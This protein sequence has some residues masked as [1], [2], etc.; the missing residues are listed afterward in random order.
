VVAQQRA[1][2]PPHTGILLSGSIPPLTDWYFQRPETGI[3][4]ASGLFPGQT[5]V[6]THGEQTATAPAAQGGTGKTQLAVDFAR[7][8]RSSGAV[9]VLVWVTATSRE[10]VLVRFAQAAGAVGAGDPDAGTEAAA[11]RFVAWLSH[12]ERPW[13]LVLD[14]L[15]D[16]A[17]LEDL[18]PAGPA[19]Q[20]VITTRVPAAALGPG[21]GRGL[22]VVPVGG[23][24]R[25]EA[26]DYLSWRLT[27]YPDQRIEALDLGE[28]LDGLPLGLAQA[29][30]VMNVKGLSCREYRVQLGERSKH[31]ATV[32][33]EGVSAPILA[34]WS[35]AAECADELAPAGLAWPALALAAMFDPDGIPGVVLTS[36]AACGYIA[37]RLSVGAAPDQAMARA[38]ITNLARAGLVSIDPASQVRTVRLHP[39]VQAAV[40][41]WIPK[42]DF[43]RLQLAAA[44]ALVQTW[45]EPDDGPLGGGVH[46]GAPGEQASGDATMLDQA[47]GDCAAHLRAAEGVGEGHER[48]ER[49]GRVER[50]QPAAAPGVMWTP[51]AHPVLFRAGLSLE[52]SGLSD[53]TIA[54]WQAMVTTCTRLLGPAHASSVASKERLALAYESAGRFGDAI[55]AFQAALADRERSQGREHPD[56]IGARG[57]LA[58]AYASAG[59]PAEAVALYEQMVADSH[60]Q[61]GLGHPVTI[62][63][64]S[65]LA[66][67]YREAGRGKDSVSAYAKLVADSERLLGAGHPATLAA[68]EDL[69]DACLANGQA[70]DA[71]EQYRRVLGT[72]EAARGRDHPDVIAA[73]SSLASALRRSGK[74]KDAIT[75][76]D[77]V[78][79]DRERAQGA[80]HPD[81][82][83]ARA[84]LA[85]AYRSAGQLREAIP[86]YERTLEDRERVQGPDHADSRAARCNLAGAYQ[87]AGRVPDAVRQYERALADS[88]RM[89]GPA[90]SETMTTR[91]SLASALFAEGRL[92][93]A[94]ALL[95]RALADA[96]RTLGPDHPMTQ[97]VRA[98]LDTA[99]MT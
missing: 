84:N 16:P 79:T 47:F 42:A 43:D 12:T 54:Y 91:G 35:M 88:E 10:A 73:R 82:I 65:G 48:A 15:T 19:G 92:M 6:L 78:L 46:G 38:A 34:T 69:A 28:D 80:D 76:Y 86:V 93:E 8:L 23:F 74:L 5:V 45:P 18:W 50:V 64:R 1:G 3:D 22:R 85:F 58:H 53:A 2:A 62:R 97:A 52:N 94:I 63:A 71:V 96:E 81:T 36:A 40:R 98:S 83:A 77:R 33:V 51:E 14:D 39:T 70:G 31:M 37:G 27:D 21:A 87:Q 13:A 89:L 17:H 60:R 25:R 95:R 90:D 24:S 57:Q 75:Q 30:A 41:A 44:D 32:P 59:R 9:E 72:L 68:R 49:A 4:L 61:L 26:L 66:Q 20:V 56:T 67:A 55:A 99:T 29:V 7:G 11:A